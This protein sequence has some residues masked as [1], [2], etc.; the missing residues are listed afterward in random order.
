[1]V[2]AKIKEGMTGEEADSLSRTF[3]G[4]RDFDKAFGHSLGHGVGLAPH[5]GPHLNPRWDD[6]FA[7]GDFF[8]AEPGLYH[9]SLRHGVRLEENYVVTTDGVRRLTDYR[10]DL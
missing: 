10:L 3:F 8:A 1:M 7:E 6:V 4:Q 2:I 5:E 9:D